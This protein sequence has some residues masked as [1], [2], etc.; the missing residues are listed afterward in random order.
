MVITGGIF[1][2]VGLLHLGRIVWGWPIAIGSFMP[3]MWFSWIA[4]LLAFY[5]S[6]ESFRHAKHAH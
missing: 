2:V 1:F 3:P 6:Y 5:L 4:C